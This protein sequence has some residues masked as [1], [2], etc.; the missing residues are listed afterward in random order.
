MFSSREIIDIIFLRLVAL[1][2]RSYFVEELL[3]I[4]EEVCCTKVQSSHFIFNES[5]S[6]VQRNTSM[7]VACT[8]V[9]SLE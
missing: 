5:F 9:Q 4:E 3:S 1:R 8:K 7:E 2:F 6:L